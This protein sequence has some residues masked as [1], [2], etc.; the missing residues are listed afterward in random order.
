MYY[1]L[2]TSNQINTTWITDHRLTLGQS[3]NGLVPSGNNG[4]KIKVK[5]KIYF[6]HFQEPTVVV[7][8]ETEND[9]GK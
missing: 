5:K 7:Q 4:L 1:L 6:W 3:G 9:H 2:E 8:E